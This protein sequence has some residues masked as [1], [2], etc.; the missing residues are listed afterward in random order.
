MAKTSTTVVVKRLP[1]KRHPLPAYWQG[2][3]QRTHDWPK[4][5][6]N[7]ESGELRK[8]AQPTKSQ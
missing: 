3:S 1:V 4:S 7:G 5:Y 6:G 8:P 2:K